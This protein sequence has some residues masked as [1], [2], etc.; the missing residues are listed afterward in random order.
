MTRISLSLI[1]AGH[2]KDVKFQSVLWSSPRSEETRAQRICS[3]SEV[4]KLCGKDQVMGDG[5]GQEKDFIWVCRPESVQKGFLETIQ[6]PG[7]KR[8]GCLSSGVTR[9]KKMLCLGTSGME[10]CPPALKRKPRP[11]H[12]ENQ[13]TDVVTL[14]ALLSSLVR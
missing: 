6:E 10:A 7:L 11:R 8:S 13:V 3:Q 1:R 12:C 4:S 14:Q 2:L 9:Y 5:T